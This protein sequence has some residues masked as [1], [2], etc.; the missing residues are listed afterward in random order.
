MGNLEMIAVGMKIIVRSQAINGKQNDMGLDRLGSQR[1]QRK[2]NSEKEEKA[3][4]SIS[5]RR[6]FLL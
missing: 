4:H 2:H 5:L 3:E 6:S 1:V